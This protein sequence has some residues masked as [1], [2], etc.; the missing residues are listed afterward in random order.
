[1]LIGSSIDTIEKIAIVGWSSKKSDLKWGDDIK[2]VLIPQLLEEITTKLRETSSLKQAVPESFPLLRA[3]QMAI[4][5]EKRWPH[6]KAIQPT[7]KGG[8]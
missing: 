7:A 2:V 3:I 1:L 5:F 4:A 6:N 8:G